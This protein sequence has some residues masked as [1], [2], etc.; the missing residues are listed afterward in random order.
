MSSGTPTAPPPDLLECLREAGLRIDG[1]DGGPATTTGDTDVELRAA[2]E[3]AALGWAPRRGA[4]EITGGDRVPYLQRMLTQELLS[5]GAGDLRRGLLLDRKGRIEADLDL[6]FEADR[7]LV[8]TAPR[9]VG[10]A[11]ETLERYALRDEV[12]FEDLRATRVVLHLVGPAAPSVL[13]AAGGDPVPPTEAATMDLGDLRIRMTRS[14]RL[15]PSGL[16]LVVEA[17]DAARLWRR[18]M[19]A[20]E[21][22]GIRPMGTEAAEILRIEAGVPAHGAE[23][24]ASEF[25]QEARLDAAV[26][27][28]KGCYL[29]Q[30]TVARIHHRGKVNRL[31]SGLESTRRLEAGTGLVAEGREVGAVTSAVRRPAGDWV[32]LG[33]VRVE[34]AEPGTLLEIAAGEDGPEEGPGSARVRDIAWWGGSERTVADSAAVS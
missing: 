13:R 17:D 19:Q 27:H 2:R 34:H 20:G 26:D 32:A 33:Y 9:G 22:E 21:A 6:G 30:E 8:V 3:G 10:E 23:I 12:H 25:P 14:P 24:T 11:I 1:G 29:G 7:I 15:V 4:F 28:D 18:L 16:E 5:A 31:L